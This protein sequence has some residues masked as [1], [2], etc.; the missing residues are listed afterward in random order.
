MK[1]IKV[2]ITG[3]YEADETDD[4]NYP[5]GNPAAQ[6]AQALEN[7]EFGYDDL[8][9]MLDTTLETKFSYV[10]EEHTYTRDS[11]PK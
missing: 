7:G 4:Q 6:D 8:L 3:T 9:S 10:T 1:K 11:L 2:T 5:S